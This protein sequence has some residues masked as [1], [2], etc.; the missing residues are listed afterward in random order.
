MV[1]FKGIFKI[2]NTLQ[3]LSELNAVAYDYYEKVR[4]HGGADM[5][6]LKYFLLCLDRVY[7]EGYES[8]LRDDE[9]D[10]IHE[11]YLDN[12]GEVI[13]GDMSSTDKA[14]HAYPDLKGTIRKVHFITEKDRLKTG[15]VKSQKSLEAWL[16][17]ILKS[18]DESGQ[19]DEDMIL[20]FYTKF[21][22]LSVVLEVEDGIVKSAITRGD[23]DTGEG[24]NK[25]G[26]FRY[27]DFSDQC[28]KLGVRKF[29]M[30]CEA[31]V[32]KSDFDKYNK[33]FGGGKLI[34]ERSAATSIMNNEYPTPEQVKFLGLMPL[35]LEIDGVEYPMPPWDAVNDPMIDRIDNAFDWIG[36]TFPSAHLIIH[37]EKPNEIAFILHAI[38]QIIDM[39]MKQ[40]DKLNY[41]V[42]GIVIRILNEK[43][44]RY[45]GR[46]TDDCVNNWERAY[47]FP[48]AQSKT[49]IRSIEQEI[50]LLGK[51]S[52]IAKVN[53]VKLKNK[54]IKSISIG[55]LDRFKSLDLAIGDE[56]IVQYDI[57]PY[58]TR[59]SSCKRSN[60]HPID[61]IVNC[62][63][64]G[65]KLEMAPELS[66]VNPECPSR[67][68]GK[69]Y[70]YCA[71]IGIEGI[72]EETIATLYRNGFV[73]SIPDLYEL[74][75]Y[76]DEIKSIDGFGSTSVK[77]MLKAIDSVNKVDDYV[78]LGSMGI[79]SVGRKMFAKIL[80]VIP[81]DELISMPNNKMS[82]NKLLVIPGVKSK[83]A[84]RILDGL[85]AISGDLYKIMHYVKVTKPDKYKMLV[86]FTKIRDHDFEKYLISQGIGISDD[87]TKD[88]SYL[89]AGGNSSSKIDKAR[90]YK[91]PIIDINTAYKKFGY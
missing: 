73:K 3:M 12:G 8:P 90:K 15:K 58:L 74:H 86:C 75:K 78:L 48:P 9:Y 7:Q 66:C 71:K 47:K 13:R 42:D 14:V 35:M 6:Q 68:V 91:I 87:M 19:L 37:R 17:S 76:K 61:A 64:C 55:S 52:F 2:K 41:P 34:D 63:V 83:T 21:D 51:V 50:G 36:D 89:I 23:K 25:T 20:G 33:R 11:L 46:N 81:F 16:R 79:P 69:I 30:K 80:S 29:G 85:R 26:L 45:L 38:E 53:P 18:L 31:L 60:N 56:V 57:I 1:D 39:M 82:E 44:R 65:E 54:T 70:N 24:Q 72:G 62:P 49:V 88:V 10:E 67:I 32:A 43:Y 22:G 84:R 77:K 59:D 4:Q 27:I 40:I 5:E 28:K